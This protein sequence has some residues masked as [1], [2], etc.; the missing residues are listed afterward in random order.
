MGFRNRFGRGWG[1]IVLV[2]R[3]EMGIWVNGNL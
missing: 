1:L 3:E 2:R